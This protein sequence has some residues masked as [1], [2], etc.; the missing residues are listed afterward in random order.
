M[1]SQTT[2]PE[3]PG[4]GAASST[5]QS[6]ESVATAGEFHSIPGAAPKAK[7][8]ATLDAAAAAADEAEEQQRFLIAS[9]PAGVNLLSHLPAADPATS[10]A[11][12]AASTPV[13]FGQVLQ[14][15]LHRLSIWTSSDNIAL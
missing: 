13:S 9:S 15:M 7:T 14:Q 4:P 11:A 6:S 1:Q 12:P 5:G 10:E 2:P 3:K 8:E